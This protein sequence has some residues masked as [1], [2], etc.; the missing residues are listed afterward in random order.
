MSN[1]THAQRI[2][3]LEL[4]THLDRNLA[5]EIKNP[6]ARDLLLD[7]LVH[8]Q[9]GS[10]AIFGTMPIDFD[11]LDE[12]GEPKEL[13]PLIAELKATPRGN[14][15]MELLDQSADVEAEYKNA[16]DQARLDEIAKMSPAQQMNYARKNGL[17]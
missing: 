16:R 3:E 11:D 8:T 6:H 2:I 5:H 15:L 17:L 4:R 7:Q 14:D 10:A 13:V 1:M 9:R 12:N